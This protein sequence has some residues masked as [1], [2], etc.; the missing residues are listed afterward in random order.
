MKKV[1]TLLLALMFIV[2]LFAGCGGAN[3]NTGADTGANAGANTGTNTGGDDAAEAT[4]EPV[5][6]SPYKFAA[7]K[8]EVDENGWPVD[9]YEYELPL[10]TTDE[11]LTNMTTN[12]TPQYLPEDNYKG[13]PTYSEAIKMTGVNVEYNIIALS[14]FADTLSVNEAA[15]ALDDII[16][17]FR[18]FHKGSTLAE[19]VEDE[20]VVNLYEYKDY[21]PNYCWYVNHYSYDDS[22]MGSVYNPSETV[23]AGFT[24]FYS[25]P[26]SAT[27]YFIR[28]D[29]LDKLGLGLAT[30]FWTFDEFHDILTAIKTGIEGTF[31][32]ILFSAIDGQPY[33]WN[34]YNTSPTSSGIIYNRVI[35][36]KVYFNGTTQDDK[37]LMT[38]LYTWYSE[39]LVDPNFSS[40]TDTNSESKALTND[41]VATAMFNPSEVLGW[42]EASINPDCTWQPINRLRKSTNDTIHWNLGQDMN[43]GAGS[44]IMASCE[45]I[46]LACMW[47]DW[48][49][50]DFGADWMNWGPEGWGWEYKEDGTR[51]WTDMVI[52]SEA[53]VGWI[54]MCWFFNP[55]DA[56]INEW[57]RNYYYPGGERLLAMYEPW[58]YANEHFYDGAYNYPQKIKLSDE[59]TAEIASIR[60]D[61]N[62]YFTENYVRFVDGSKPLSEWDSFQADLNNLGYTRIQEIYQQYYDEFIAG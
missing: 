9:K 28:Q 52:N 53:G 40:Y 61:L 55:M 62:T 36:G 19:A 27:G 51:Q 20:L 33:N 43:G 8:Y 5:E 56:G 14:T 10:C 25:E 30:D 1:I 39:G 23:W 16:A 41:G 15:D 3:K 21:L 44:S 18:A 60:T 2:A 17:G 6:D 46:E 59:D 24:D 42:E 48:C 7:G 37:D 4:A 50:S 26:I 34:A 29:F 45:N 22:L 11:V 38:L 57:T 31:P 47:I 32:L 35:D 49:Y 12:F 54:T 58:N 13:I